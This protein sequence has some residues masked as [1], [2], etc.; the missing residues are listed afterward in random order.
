MKTRVFVFYAISF[1]SL[2]LFIFSPVA[3]GELMESILSNLQVS[4]VLIES[5][6]HMVSVKQ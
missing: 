3:S 2:S 1:L 4:S 6:D 5:A